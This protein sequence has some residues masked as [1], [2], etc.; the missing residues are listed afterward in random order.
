MEKA[1]VK[2]L[3]FIW[4]IASELDSVTEKQRDPF[5][6]FYIKKIHFSIET[7]KSKM[8]ERRMKDNMFLLSAAEAKPFCDAGND[9]KES[10][11]LR[12]PGTDSIHKVQWASDYVGI[13]EIGSLVNTSMGVRPGIH[14]SKEALNKGT[15]TKR[16]FLEFGYYG[17]KVIKWKVLDKETGF[18]IMKKPICFSEFDSE[19]ADYQD[20]KIRYF[21][22]H[23]LY[24]E[25]FTQHEKE[26]IL[27]VIINGEGHCFA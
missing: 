25:I 23:W 2:A 5:Q 16:G 22:N 15:W 12:T 3:C 18:L 7:K 9:C 13:S 4:K 6:F 26:M 10:W 21:I 1:I 27:P 17:G 24:D 11:W 8:G 19:T 20:S 14:L